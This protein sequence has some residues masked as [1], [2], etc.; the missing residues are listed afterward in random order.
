[1]YPVKS[2]LSSEHVLKDSKD[3]HSALMLKLKDQ[4]AKWMEE[5]LKSFC[6]VNCSYPE[7]DEVNEICA[8]LSARAKALGHDIPASDILRLYRKRFPQLSKHIKPVKPRRK[9]EVVSLTNLCLIQD[10]NGKVVAMDKK[11]GHDLGTTLPGGHRESYETLQEAVVREVEEETGLVIVSPEFCGV[12]HW[13]RNDVHH[14]IFLYKADKFSGTLRSSKE[15][16]VYW[17]ELDKLRKKKELALGIKQV[18]EMLVDGRAKEC[19]MQFGP[20]ERE[21]FC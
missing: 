1:M 11:D 5:E 3:A 9:R 17:L 13:E 8:R 2:K 18:L 12:Y 10:G 6:S 21:K 19:Y 20:V 16:E 4:V 14:I 15:G 7:E